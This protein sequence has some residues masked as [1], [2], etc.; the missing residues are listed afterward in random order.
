M[1]KQSFNNAIL[2]YTCISMIMEHVDLFC[3]TDSDNNL[4]MIKYNLEG[5]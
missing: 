5:N 4:L 2:N 3:S 1:S